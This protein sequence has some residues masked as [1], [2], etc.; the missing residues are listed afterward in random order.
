M[1]R[2]VTDRRQGPRRCGRDGRWAEARVRPGRDVEVVDLGA[3]GALLEGST[4]LMPGTQVVL[5]LRGEGR[6]LAV[7]CRVVRCEVVALDPD[8]GIRYRG[9]V[10]FDAPYPLWGESTTQHG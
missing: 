5:I 9:A 3:G 8:K 4:R 10:C 6:S 2:E 7:R 1:D